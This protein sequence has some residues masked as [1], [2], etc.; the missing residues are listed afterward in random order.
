MLELIISASMAAMVQVNFRKKKKVSWKEISYY[1]E[2]E[3]L[4]WMV[5]G[6]LN[7]I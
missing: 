5:G 1:L 7:E 2:F 6:N 4:T 3:C